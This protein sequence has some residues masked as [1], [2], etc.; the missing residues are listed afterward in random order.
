MTASIDI[1][2]DPPVQ[3]QPLEIC[4]NGTLP[5]TL[6]ITWVPAGSPTSV[7]CPKPNGCA[8]ITVPSN[9]VSINIHD[10][11]GD[12]EDESRTVDPE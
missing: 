3:G 12:A 8:T 1:D 10:P 5:H 6:E 7:T 2:P 9:A 4:Y 11:S